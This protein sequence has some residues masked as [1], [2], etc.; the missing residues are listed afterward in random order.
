MKSVKKILILLLSIATLTACGSKEKEVVVNKDGTKYEVSEAV[1][2]Y[3]P[4]GYQQAKTANAKSVALDEEYKILMFNK[5]NQSYFYTGIED[6][7]ENVIEEKEVLFVASLEEDKATID[8]TT[9]IELESGITVLQVKGNYQETGVNFILIVYFEEK[10][11]HVLGYFANSEDFK[12][13]VNQ[14]ETFLETLTVQSE[15]N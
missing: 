7:T 3:Y 1:N 5:E 10:T 9:D 14:V 6:E 8:S 2:F 4:A 11:T 15:T 13:N 12:D